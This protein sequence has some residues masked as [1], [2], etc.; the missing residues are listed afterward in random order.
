MGNLLERIYMEIICYEED[1]VR[2]ENELA[3]EIDRLAAPYRKK[4]SKKQMAQ[5]KAVLYEAAS[6]A[7]VKAFWLGMRYASRLRGKL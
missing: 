1:A 3:G 2:M 4:V 7:E 5:F 6:A